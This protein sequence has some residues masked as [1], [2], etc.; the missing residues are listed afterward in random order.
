MLLKE[1]AAAPPS[2]AV[3]ESVRGQVIRA[4]AWTLG[5]PISVFMLGINKASDGTHVLRTI[6][7]IVVEECLIPTQLSPPLNF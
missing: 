6:H 7:Y 4:C 5:F 2:R 1:S 3:W